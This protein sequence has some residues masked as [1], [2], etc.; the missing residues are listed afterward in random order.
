MKTTY[1]KLPKIF[2]DKWLKALRGGEYK[3]GKTKLHSDGKYCCLGVACRI[4]G[5]STKRIGYNALINNNLINVRVPNIL[6]CESLRD[7]IIVSKLAHMNDGVSDN[8]ISKAPT[9]SFKQI[10]NWIESN[11]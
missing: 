6:K 7:S 3:Q 9:R 8:G 1:P 5:A 10:A 11:L 2:K 4:A